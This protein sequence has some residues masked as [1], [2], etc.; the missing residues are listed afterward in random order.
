[1][2]DF[3]P[4]RAWLLIVVALVG[5]R[6]ARYVVEHIIHS[7]SRR[8]ITKPPEDLG[9]RTTGQLARSGAI[10]AALLGFSIFIFTPY[11]E[12]FARSPQFYRVLMGGLGTWVLYTVPAG[13]IAG[14]IQPFIRGFHESYQR[15]TQPRRFWA[16][17][18]W[19]ALLGCGFI[20]LTFQDF[21][22]AQSD[23]QIERCY[24]E[25]GAYSPQ[26][27]IPACTLLIDSGESSPARLSDFIVSRGIAYQQAGDQARA[28]ADYDRAIRLNPNDY[29]AFYNRG[30]AYAD[31]GDPPQAV[32]D[33]TVA[34]R[35]RPKDSDAY[36]QRGV[37][38]LNTHRLDEALAD[39]NTAHELSPNDPWPLANRG[40]IYAW[41]KDE[42][43][44]RQDL[45]AVRAADPTNF[46][47]L[48]GEAILAMGARD[49]DTAVARLSEALK[50]NPSDKWA[51]GLR[52]DAY[53][54]LGEQD[55]ADADSDRL[56]LLNVKEKQAQSAKGA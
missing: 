52:S 16:S 5:W 14:R 4:V 18:S 38:A 28:M 40:I 51:L 6:P 35:L 45:K 8:D 7:P 44:A 27:V 15:E 29:Y 32:A 33:F 9:W 56:W 23:S 41:K 22:D 43:R 46:V 48:H 3:V 36:L 10:L 12:E 30:L 54:L 53:E 11:A 26:D 47:L 49:Y 20:W 13:I 50:Q 31:R 2:F 17:L 34:I 39:F 25:K 55:K 19:N 24:D 21:S 37:I 42:V 1:M